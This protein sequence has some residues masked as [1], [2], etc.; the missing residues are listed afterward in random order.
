MIEQGF[1]YTFSILKEMSDFF[2]TRVKNLEPKEG[3]KK[4]SA[5]AKKTNK[6]SANKNKGENSNSIVIE[7]SEESIVE[8]RPNRKYCIVH[9]KCSHS[10]NNYNDLCDM[11]KTYGKT[12]RNYML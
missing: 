2:E 10:M 5:T 12:A 6:K 9:G 7:S 1:N 8:R 4:S 3:K 11:I